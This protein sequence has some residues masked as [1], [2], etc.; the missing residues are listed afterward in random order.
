MR[1]NPR[2]AAVFGISGTRGN[3]FKKPKKILDI[4]MMGSCTQFD[5]SVVF[6][7][8]SKHK[9]TEESTDILYRSK[10][11]NSYGL[12]RASRGLNKSR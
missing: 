5:V 6:L 3:F 9:L 11:R 1:A 8:V 10:H 7:L 12:L 2:E 4:L